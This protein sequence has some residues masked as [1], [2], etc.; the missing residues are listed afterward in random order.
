M[1]AVQYNK[2]RSQ[3][4]TWHRRMSRVCLC[5]RH[6]RAWRSPYRTSV[7]L[8]LEN[9][10]YSKH[11]FDK[12]LLCISIWTVAART[13]NHVRLSAEH[14]VNWTSSNNKWVILYQPHTVCIILLAYKKFIIIICDDVSLMTTW[15]GHTRH[16][17]ANDIVCKG[18]A[19]PQAFDIHPRT[20]IRWKNHSV[21][22]CGSCRSMAGSNRI[23]L[24]LLGMWWWRRSSEK[25]PEDMTRTSD[26]W[27]TINR[28]TE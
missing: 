23:E 27:K 9:A 16:V 18:K 24:E 17:S 22:V 25:Q 15:Y 8:D 4:A 11:T 10:L 2:P 20:I 26:N 21:I 1:S 5:F 3:W 19:T 14:R 13:Q 12:A 7:R 6:G 28:L